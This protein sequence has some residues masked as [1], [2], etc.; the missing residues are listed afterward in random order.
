MDG[1][2]TASRNPYKAPEKNPQQGA[3]RRHDLLTLNYYNEAWAG[4]D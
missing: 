1:C 2:S 4:P 3:F